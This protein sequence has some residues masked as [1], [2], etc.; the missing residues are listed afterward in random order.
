MLQSWEDSI[1]L[2]E[3]QRERFANLFLRKLLQNL[4]NKDCKNK[5]ELKQFIEA[6]DRIREKELRM[7]KNN[8]EKSVHNQWLIEILSRIR[9]K[10]ADSLDC[11]E[12]MKED[13]YAE[14]KINQALGPLFT[15]NK[16]KV[17][18]AFLMQV[19]LL[20]IMYKLIMQQ[21]RLV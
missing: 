17:A 18:Q 5:L 14:G 8:M 4:V 12:F 2:T 20:K 10:L 15:L 1:M 9:Y 3:E 21:I 6:K 16:E 11:Y 7:Q 19:E 13:L